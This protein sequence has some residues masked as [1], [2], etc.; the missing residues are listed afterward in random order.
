[1]LLIDGKKPTEII[2][3][4][5]FPKVIIFELVEPARGRRITANGTKKVNSTYL[6]PLKYLLNDPET[7][8]SKE[9]LYSANGLVQRD[10]FGNILPSYEPEPFKMNGD[11]VLKK[12]EDAGLVYALIHSIYCESNP[13]YKGDQASR[14]KP[15]FRVKNM[16]NNNQAEL[17]NFRRM[18]EAMT[19]ISDE[20]KL[21]KEKVAKLYK[22][23]G[24]S[25]AETLLI[26]EEYDT[27]RKLLAELASKD[28]NKF[29]A[30]FEDGL[31]DTRATIN[32]ALEAKI[33]NLKDGAFTWGA[34]A[35]KNTPKIFSAPKGKEQGEAIE[36]FINH[37]RLKDDTGVFDEIKKL[38]GKK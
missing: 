38:L 19:I 35:N 31:A 16:K 18:A 9:I 2:V 13:V 24:Q 4:S 37:L 27:M 34:E 7:G 10:G 33:I 23:W 8:Q 1:M 11:V 12:K 6:I 20:V 28:P 21:T 32:D 30:I 15:I 26:N 29:F 3:P 5:E 14:L 22:A 25:D 17:S 36:L